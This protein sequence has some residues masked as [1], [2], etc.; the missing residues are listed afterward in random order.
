MELVKAVEYFGENFIKTILK[1]DFVCKKNKKIEIKT[2]DNLKIINESFETN[3]K[4]C[5][6]CNRC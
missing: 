4:P 2:F 1:K 3:K 6:N 5:L